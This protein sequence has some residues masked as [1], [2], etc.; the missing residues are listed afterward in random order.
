MSGGARITPSHL[1]LVPGERTDG[2]EV[3]V[4]RLPASPRLDRFAAASAEAGLELREAVRL[5]IDH[6][7]ALQDAGAFGLDADTARRLL[8]RAAAGA[9]ASRPLGARSAEQVR[10][11]GSGSPKPA[12]SLPD[13]LEVELSERVLARIGAP[14][15][16]AAI[17]PAVVEEMISW[18]I[19]ATLAGRTLGEW[20]LHALA[21]GRAAA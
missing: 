21:R 18:Q 6:A 20:A 12:A 14:L 1:Q 15:T 5:A 4:L 19:A 3:Q 9:R 13:G 16:E 7:L 17:R 8:N 10:R 2:C 11:L